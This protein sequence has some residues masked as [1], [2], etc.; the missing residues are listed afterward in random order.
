MSWQEIG[1][2][3]CVAMLL[4]DIGFYYIE[5]IICHAHSV[6]NYQHIDRMYHYFT[7]FSMHLVSLDFQSIIIQYIISNC[8]AV[9]TKIFFILYTRT[10]LSSIVYELMHS[11]FTISCLLL[12]MTNIIVQFILTMNGLSQGFYVH[13]LLHY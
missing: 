11:S 8:I 13:W 9:V 4:W 2:R 12:S 5:K 1:T 3:K 6:F 10:P 7:A